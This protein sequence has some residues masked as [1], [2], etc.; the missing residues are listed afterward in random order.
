MVKDLLEDAG[1]DTAVV[2]LSAVS[3]AAFAKVAEFCQHHAG[4]DADAGQ[5]TAAWDEAFVA[6]LTLEQM[7]ELVNAANFLNM[8]H[9]MDLIA[10]RFA[11]MMR[12]K[13]VEEIRRSFGI[14]NDF[15]PEEETAV[16]A[17]N[18]WAFE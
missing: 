14:K 13:S 10:K 7:Y 12:G 9:V 2:P 16:R 6:A 1:L 3:S 15:T 5:Q 11:E 18:S 4:A 8:P 17:A